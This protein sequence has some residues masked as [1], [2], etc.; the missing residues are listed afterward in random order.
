MS[1]LNVVGV[2]DANGVGNQVRARVLGMF[3]LVSD[4]PAGVAVVVADHEPAAIGEHPAETL[5]PPEH[6]PPDAHDEQ[7]RWIGEVAKGLRAELD[8]AHVD[9]ALSQLPTS[10]VGLPTF[11]R[12]LSCPPANSLTTLK[13]SM[14][15]PIVIPPS[16]SIDRLYRRGGQASI[17]EER[18]RRD[19]GADSLGHR[20]AR[21]RGRRP[22]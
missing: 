7:D 1:S 21:G 2:E 6:R 20:D 3:R 8:T 4:G 12:F 10:Y 17:L 9:H 19:P 5:R 14:S 22:P 11:T 15:S 16:P 18:G 13:A